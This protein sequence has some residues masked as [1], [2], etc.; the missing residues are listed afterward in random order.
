MRHI[1]KHQGTPVLLLGHTSSNAGGSRM[2]AFVELEKL[3]SLE[4][5]FI[6]Q[7]FGLYYKEK[8][9]LN[10][11][12]GLSM[13]AQGRNVNAG[14]YLMQ[15]AE[16]RPFHDVSFSDKEQT[17]EWD[18]G[19]LSRFDPE[20]PEDN[21]ILNEF[22]RYAGISSVLPSME[23][24]PSKPASTMTDVAKPSA[25]NY[26]PK[27]SSSSVS[28]EKYDELYGLVNKQ[29]KQMADMTK[30]IRSLQREIKKAGVTVEKTL[31]PL[32]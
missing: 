11:F 8:T 6:L 5:S 27:E 13:P 21:V 20:L 3:S 19:N 4:Q 9:L 2:V 16:T 25:P 14:S 23:T 18:N 30:A 22:R 32:K 17:L 31:E 1:G 7:Q 24:G 26:E 15:K 29:N 12:N 28:Q 10:V